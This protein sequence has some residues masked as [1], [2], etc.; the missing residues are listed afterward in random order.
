MLAALRVQTADCYADAGPPAGLGSSGLSED[1]CCGGR[2]NALA[3]AFPIAAYSGAMLTLRCWSAIVGQGLEVAGT[4][5]QGLSVPCD[6]R[7]LPPAIAPAQP[8]A[9]ARYLGGSSR[10]LCS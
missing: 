8:T 5:W 7:E 1:R 10:P 9:A 3:I 6:N 2:P 4:K